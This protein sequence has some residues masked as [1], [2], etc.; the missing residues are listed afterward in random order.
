MG[1]NRFNVLALPL[2]IVPDRRP[3]RMQ[4][5]WLGSAAAPS[6]RDLCT[7]QVYKRGKLSLSFGVPSFPWFF[8][9]RR[10]VR[11]RGLR[12]NSRPSFLPFVLDGHVEGSGAAPAVGL[13][14]GVYGA[15][16]DGT[17]VKVQRRLLA[18]TRAKPYWDGWDS[19]A[20]IWLE[21]CFSFIS[22]GEASRNVRRAALLRRFRNQLDGTLLR[23]ALF[24]N[25]SGIDYSLH[26]PRECSKNRPC[27]GTDAFPKHSRNRGLRLI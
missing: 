11:I 14:V 9:A 24:K 25:I 26:V 21:L 7:D 2:P 19:W 22:S 23:S 4:I 1:F 13:R 16:F 3:R 6:L 17:L 12:P 15:V 10:L 20:Q 18:P 8:G 5:V 27:S